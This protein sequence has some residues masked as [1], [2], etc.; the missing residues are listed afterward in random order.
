MCN[1]NN[2][3]PFFFQIHY[4]LFHCFYASTSMLLAGS[5]RITKSVFLINAL[6]R[7]VFV[8]SP[9][10]SFLVFLSSSSSKLKNFIYFTKFFWKFIFF[11]KYFTGSSILFKWNIILH[12]L[13]LFSV[14]SNTV[15]AKF[16]HTCHPFNKSG[17]SASVS[18][19]RCIY[20]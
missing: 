3:F 4:K 7:A 17:F 2:R 6:K 13:K 20:Y 18:S 1:Q 16:L 11:F 5:S 8:F 14:I 19:C 10:E 15:L 9:P 12:F